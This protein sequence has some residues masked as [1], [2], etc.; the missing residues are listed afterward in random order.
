MGPIDYTAI[1]DKKRQHRAALNDMIVSEYQ[2]KQRPQY[3]LIRTSTSGKALAVDS[4]LV[5][6]QSLIHSIAG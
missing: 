2:V 3:A 4:C 5:Y 6:L 1:K